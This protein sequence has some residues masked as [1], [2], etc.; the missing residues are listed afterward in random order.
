MSSREAACNNVRR[1]TFSLVKPGCAVIESKY[2]IGKLD[3]RLD[4]RNVGWNG[5]S[6]SAAAEEKTKKGQRN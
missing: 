1:R 3:S 4:L 6:N 5:A 2:E